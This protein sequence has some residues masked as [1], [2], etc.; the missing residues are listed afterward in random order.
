M[1]MYGEGFELM[2]VMEVTKKYLRE[3][4]K[5]DARV[6]CENQRHKSNQIVAVLTIFA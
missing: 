1:N 5:T 3:Q 6:T 4:N 2:L